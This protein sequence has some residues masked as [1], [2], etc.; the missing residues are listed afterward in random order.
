M[1]IRICMC[2]CT[3]THI[4]KYNLLGPYDATCRNAFRDDYLPLD[5]QLVR[6]SLRKTTSPIPRLPRLPI[7]LSIGLRPCWLLPVQLGLT[8]GVTLVQLVFGWL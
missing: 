6:S 3:Y 1:H 7:A 5:N 8:I 2:I 4:P